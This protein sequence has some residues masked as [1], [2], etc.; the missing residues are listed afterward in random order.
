MADE[1][2]KRRIIYEYPF[3]ESYLEPNG[4]LKMDPACH[5]CFYY[6]MLATKALALQGNSIESQTILY[7]VGDTPPPWFFANLEQIARSVATIYALE[8][9]D[10][11]LNYKK[12]VWTQGQMIGVDMDPIIF[13]IA[14]GKRLDS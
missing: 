2:L 3:Y 8:S 14:P 13:E 5:A 11:F 9:P 6:A 4:A 1:S 7:K 10:N 12:E